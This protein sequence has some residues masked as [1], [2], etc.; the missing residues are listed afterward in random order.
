M[1][2]YRRGEVAGHSAG[3]HRLSNYLPAYALCDTKIGMWARTQVELDTAAGELISERFGAYDK[4]R[5]D[6][7]ATARTSSR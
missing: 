6:R 5:C 7:S 2:R 4:N 3:A 1:R